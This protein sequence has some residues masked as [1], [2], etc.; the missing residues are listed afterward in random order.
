MKT[1]NIKKLGIGIL[2]TLLALSTAVIIKNNVK[3][4]QHECAT[5]AKGN[6]EAVFL[7]IF[8]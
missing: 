8:H 4:I 7:S 6:S 2:F 1:S 5:S 3:V